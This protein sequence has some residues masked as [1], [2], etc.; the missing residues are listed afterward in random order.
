MVVSRQRVAQNARTQLA[1]RRRLSAT[2]LPEKR[3]DQPELVG[4]NE[5]SRTEKKSSGVI[6][7]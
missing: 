3:R 2:R 6:K 7:I 1:D 5:Q 4:K